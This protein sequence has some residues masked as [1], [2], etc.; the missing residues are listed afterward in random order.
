ML[1]EIPQKAGGFDQSTSS[2]ISDKRNTTMVA[3]EIP[4]N[5]GNSHQAN[6][7]NS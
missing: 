4:P 3:C 7:L 5:A 1:F 6:L 2:Y